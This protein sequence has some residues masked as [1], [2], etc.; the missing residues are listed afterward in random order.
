MFSRV[1]YAKNYQNGFEIPSNIH[2]LIPNSNLQ[3]IYDIFMFVVQVDNCF[4]KIIFSRRFLHSN[5]IT[6]IEK[7]AFDGLDLNQLWVNWRIKLFPWELKLG[8]WYINK[9]IYFIVFF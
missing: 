3:C 5:A 2:T 1:K 4:T 6:K 7:E 9:L 8:M